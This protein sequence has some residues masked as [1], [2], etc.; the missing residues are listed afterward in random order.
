MYILG[1]PYVGDGT[2]QKFLSIVID[3]DKDLCYLEA[4]IIPK[5]T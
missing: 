2:S 3:V 4:S 5:L 1:T